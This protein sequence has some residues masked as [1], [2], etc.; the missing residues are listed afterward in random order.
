M[1][2]EKGGHDSKLWQPYRIHN[3]HL[4]VFSAFVI[5]IDVEGRIW[6]LSEHV[7]N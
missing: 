1:N 5:I 7:V 4:V 2:D 6:R 3:L